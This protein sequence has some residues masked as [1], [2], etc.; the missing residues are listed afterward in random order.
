VREYLDAFVIAGLIALFLITFVIRTF[1]IPSISMMQTL[2]VGDDLLVDELSY[3]LHPPAFGDIAVFTPPVDAKG[4]P[5]IKRVVGL[6]GDTLSV[7][8]GIV[9]RNG[10]ALVEPYENQTP[11]YNLQIRDYG[12]YVDDGT[13]TFEPLGSLDADVPPRSM[14]QAPNRIPAG[15]YFMMGDNRNNSEDSHVWGFAQLSGSF[16]AGPLSHKPVVAAFAGRA[17]LIFWP[18]SRTRLLR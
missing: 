3:R 12:I 13:G 5:F 8:D 18:L 14:W 7:A 17:F 9:Y 16:T 1:Y 15:F 6:P 11:A 10:T 2:Q 4:S